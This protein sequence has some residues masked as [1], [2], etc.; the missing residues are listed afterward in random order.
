VRAAEPADV[1]GPEVHAG[2]AIEDP[3]GHRFARAA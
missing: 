3:I 2:I 1:E